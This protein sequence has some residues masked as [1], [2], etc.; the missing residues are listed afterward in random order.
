MDSWSLCPSRATVCITVIDLQSFY[1]LD[2]FNSQ[3]AENPISPLSS[4]WHC[5]W[6]CWWRFKAHRCYRHDLTLGRVTN[7]CTHIQSSVTTHLWPLTLISQAKQKLALL[8]SLSCCYIWNGVLC[9]Q[10][11]TIIVVLCVTLTSSLDVLLS[12][13]EI[14]LLFCYILRILLKTQ[15]Q[16]TLL[17]TCSYLNS[18]HFRKSCGNVLLSVPYTK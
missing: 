18:R 2:L 14:S 6:R 5:A 17:F 7:T 15:T 13:V 3:R 1:W 10:Y 8:L 11:A 16:N 4:C 12:A 9:L